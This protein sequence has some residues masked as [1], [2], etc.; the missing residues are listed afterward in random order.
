MMVSAPAHIMMVTTL[1]MTTAATT[2][3]TTARY[4]GQR[5]GNQKLIAQYRCGI[6]A[7]RMLVGVMVVCVMMT[8]IWC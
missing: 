4:G 8:V 5:G 6:D 7:V 2:T 3:T 1:V